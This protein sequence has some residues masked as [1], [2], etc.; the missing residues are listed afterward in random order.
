MKS[1]HSNWTY[2][3]I[4]FILLILKVQNE[5]EAS[6]SGVTIRGVHLTNGHHHSELNL[7]T[8]FRYAFFFFNLQIFF[9]IKTIIL[10]CFL[11]HS[12]IERIVQKFPTYLLSPH[13]DKL[14]HYHCLPKWYICYDR[15]TYINYT[16]S[17]CK[18]HILIIITSYGTSSLP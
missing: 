10:E 16:L 12:K 13:V 7:I 4:L 3:Y 14:F 8:S 6:V 18:W 5:Q 11:L 9:L 15:W 2:F 1:S 17:K